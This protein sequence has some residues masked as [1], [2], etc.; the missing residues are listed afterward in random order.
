MEIGVG[1]G[2]E[3]EKLFPEAGEVDFKR[4]RR[5]R[6]GR[7]SVRKEGVVVLRVDT[8]FETTWGSANASWE[9]DVS[10]LPGKSRTT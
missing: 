2:L 8:F 10:T 7:K 5:R 1:A 6:A 4:S 3:L 9:G